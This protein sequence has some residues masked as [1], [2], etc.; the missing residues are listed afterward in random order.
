MLEL[1]GV[2]LVRRL[3]PGARQLVSV[4]LALVA[5]SSPLLLVVVL[6]LPRSLSPPRSHALDR[7]RGMGRGRGRTGATLG[8]RV[9]VVHEAVQQGIGGVRVAIASQS[10]QTAQVSPSPLRKL[11]RSVRRDILRRLCK[12]LNQTHQ[13]S[14]PFKSAFFGVHGFVE[15]FFHRIN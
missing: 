5:L 6:L 1:S 8:H 13:I 7:I 3:G 9:L 14:L 4:R 12:P 10:S 2:Q 15:G 11:E